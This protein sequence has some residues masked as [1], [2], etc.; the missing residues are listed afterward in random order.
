M[1]H[2]ELS[3]G[4]SLWYFAVALIWGTIAISLFVLIDSFR[5]RR[6]DTA[7]RLGRN[8]WLYRV[9]QG[10]FLGLMG[11]AQIPGVP[12]VAS[13]VAVVLVP[14]ALAQGVAYLLRVVYPAPAAL[15][16]PLAEQPAED[17]P[18]QSETV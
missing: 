2:G 9:G 17:S 13:A 12:R 7:G 16:E 10:L 15:Q 4:G 6:I 14:F 8:L 18:A 3:L 1:P 5:A 11:L